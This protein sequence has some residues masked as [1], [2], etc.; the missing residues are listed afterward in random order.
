MLELRPSTDPAGQ[1]IRTTDGTNEFSVGEMTSIAMLRNYVPWSVLG[2]G[3]ALLA[4]LPAFRGHPAAA[5]ILPVVFAV[6]AQPLFFAGS[7]LA[8]LFGG[9]VVFAAGSFAVVA[10]APWRR[11]HI[12]VLVLGLGL[13]AAWATAMLVDQRLFDILDGVRPPVAGAFSAAGLL[14]VVEVERLRSR[15]Q[16]PWNVTY[17][18]VAYLGIAIALLVAATFLG[19]V[20]IQLL[21][22]AAV[23]VLGVYPIWRGNLI[24]AFER[25][26]TSRARRDAAILAIEE[27]RGRLARDIH[28]APLQD[29]SGVIRRLE[30]LPGA[31]EEANALRDVAARLRDVA[32][33]LRPPVLDDLGLVSAILDLRDQLATAHVEWTI[34]VEVEDTTSGLRP[35]PDVELAA[36][37]VMQEA[38]ANAIAHSGGRRLRIR[39]SVGA[40][41]IEL[42]VSDDGRGFRDVEARSARRAG[43]FGL[44]SMR[45]RAEAVDAEATVASAANGSSVTFRWA[46]RQ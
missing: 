27:E 28:D 23:V 4:A 19:R 35:P 30:G 25:F 44:D 18:D 38:A 45:E 20:S 26:V 9:V 34:Y 3:L 32:T 24:M 21:V 2:M 37:R 14:A 5:A 43:H 1:L 29:L 13:A 7:F 33:A 42:T 12:A 22:V 36:L 10:F 17:V 46:A 40:A 6:T 15:L 31:K 41:A 16:G 11:W 39:G 8:T